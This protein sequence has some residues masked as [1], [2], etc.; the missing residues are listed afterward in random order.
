[1]YIRLAKSKEAERLWFIRN[2][3]IRTGCLQSYPSE[4]IEAW[5]P[6]KMPESYRT[7]VENNPFFVIDNEDGNAI[8]TGFLNLAQNSVDAIFTLPEYVGKSA[9]G[10]IIDAIKAEAKK[11]GIKQLTLDS[12]P[13]A[14][15]FYLRHGFT[16]VR[17]G[18]YYS[19]LAKAHLPCIH[20]R[21]SFQSLPFLLKILVN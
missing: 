20:M 9:A 21:F 11:R 6:L 1:M 17:H 10:L 3:A 7:M 4:I 19:A 18:N 8:S 14:E 16:P 12:T 2:Q 15:I 13:N 5:T